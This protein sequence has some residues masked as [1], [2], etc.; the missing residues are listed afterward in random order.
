MSDR[1][2]KLLIYV[3]ALV[4]LAAAYFLVGKPYLDKYNAL[5]EQK[6]VLEATLAA[7]QEAYNNQGTYRDGII[8]ATN[9][10]QQIMD[11]FPEDN[12]DEKSI[13]FAAHAETDIPM[14]FTKIKFADETKMMINGEEVQSASDVEAAAEQAQ[15]AEAEAA[16]GEAAPA[17]GQA[18]PAEGEAAP[19]EGEAT[20][21]AEQ[22]ADVGINGIAWRD[23][24][25]GL[26]FQ[27]QYAGFKDFLAYLRDYEDRIVIKTI[28]IS[29]SPE[30]DMVGGNM[31]L[32][33]YALLGEDRVLPDVVTDVEDFGTDNIFVNYNYGG[34][35]LDL[36]ADMAAD[37]VNILMGGMS[38]EALEEFGVDYFVKLNAVTAN[39]SGVTIGRGDDVAGNSYITS[40]K[41]NNSNISF[42]AKGSGG[43]YSV[44]Y[45]IGKTKYTD[46]ITKGEDGKLYLR[47]VSTYR[48]SD[49]DKVSGTFKITNKTDIPLVVIIEGD[50]PDKPRVNISEKSGDVTV[51]TR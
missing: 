26:D 31:V 4:I 34:S 28:D 8:Q 21:A 7:K 43:E 39:T 19:A 37:F 46:K 38:E 10:I 35:I 18:A 51:N 27:T 16:T 15:V 6:P 45:K 44:T 20:P 47:I 32:S 49:K 5:N 36:L 48:S 22:Q 3:G 30:I 2:K 9:R 23:T 50:D 42:S 11:E 25:I 33:Q 29:Y 41:N 14:W 12:S 24:E 1:D 40:E 13:M 17:E